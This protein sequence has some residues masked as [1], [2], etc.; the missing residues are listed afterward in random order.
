MD[1]RKYKFDDFVLEVTNINPKE[2]QDAANSAIEAMYSLLKKPQ[3]TTDYCSEHMAKLVNVSKEYGKT[4]K[5]C[6]AAQKSQVVAVD[7]LK[8]QDLVNFM[9]NTFPAARKEFLAL[10]EQYKSQI[11]NKLDQVPLLTDELKNKISPKLVSGLIELQKVVLDLKTKVDK[12]FDEIQTTN[13]SMVSC[14]KKILEK[15]KQAKSL[16]NAG[17]AAPVQPIQQ[18]SN[19]Q[20]AV[21]TFMHS[22]QNSQKQAV[23]ANR[24]PPL[25]PNNP[26]AKGSK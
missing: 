3:D 21:P 8:N 4:S 18:Q 12:A 15:V 19:A 13:K 5:G 1:S 9:N 17:G 24:Q 16:A 20:G 2:T 14:A 6:I 22:N 11:A 25:P 10:H 26:N 23:A 7:T